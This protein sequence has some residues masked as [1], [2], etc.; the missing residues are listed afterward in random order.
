MNLW[1]PVA[2]CSIAGLVV[3]IGIQTARAEGGVCHGQVNMAAALN[4][5]KA[6]KTSLG[7][8]EHDKGGWREKAVTAVNTALTET[9]AGCAAAP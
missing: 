3:S 8:A 2:L 5:L 7:K 1:K 9:Q 6:V 4:G